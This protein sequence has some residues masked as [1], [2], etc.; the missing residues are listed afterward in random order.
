[1]SMIFL[2]ISVCNGLSDID[3]RYRKSSKVKK[4]F[5]MPTYSQLSRLNKYKSCELF[6]NIFE[7]LLVKAEKNLK[8]SIYIKEFN[9]IKIID[10]SVVNIG[11][12]LSPELYH[13]DKKSTI[14]ISTLFSYGTKLI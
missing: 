14:R 9:D 4:D 2:Q 6:K 5:N 1:M 12:G 8:S 7:D 11:N 3:E 10:S 13:Q